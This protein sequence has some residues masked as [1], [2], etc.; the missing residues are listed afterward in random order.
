MNLKNISV[1]KRTQFMLLWVTIL[2]NWSVY[3]KGIFVPMRI[4]PFDK[5]EKDEDSC[6]Q[7]P[8]WSLKQTI[9]SFLLSWKLAYSIR[10]VTTHRIWLKYYYC[11]SAFKLKKYIY[12]LI[13]LWIHCSNNSN[14]YSKNINKFNNLCFKYINLKINLII[15]YND[16]LE[17]KIKF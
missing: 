7:T 12:K 11:W 6:E 17:N 9:T 5:L 16:R 10:E 13:S 3:Y 2:T 14:S 8:N 4:M 15:H 1:D